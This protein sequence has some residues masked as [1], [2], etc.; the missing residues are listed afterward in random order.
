LDLYC[1][2]GFFTLALSHARKLTGIEIDP[3]AIEAARL[4]ART[5][6]LQ[7]EFHVAKAEEFD[8]IRSCPQVVILDP[9]RSG[10]HPG[11]IK[12]MRFVKPERIIY[13]SC[14][15]ARFA[16]ELPFL[17]DHYHVKDMRALDLFPHTPHVEL[18]TLLERL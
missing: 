12:T 15:F 10:L 3:A 9:P 14:N 2:S 5:N 7:A 6:G 4:N 17:L 13:V 1:G 16:Q 11:V 8:W 18:V